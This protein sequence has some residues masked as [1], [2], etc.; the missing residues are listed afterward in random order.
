MSSIAILDLDGVIVDISL[1]A[2][3]ALELAET[4][5][6]SLYPDPDSETYK[7]ARRTFFY[8]ER[9]VFNVELIEL[10]RLILGCEKALEQLV[11]EYDKVVVLTSRQQSMRE[12]TLK[13]FSQSCPGFESI[14]FI[15]KDSDEQTIKTSTWKASV[16]ARF[17]ESYDTLL[18]I[19]DDERNRKAVEEAALGNVVIV[20]ERELVRNL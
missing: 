3:K 4:F 7:K 14:E 11:Q 20:I 9:G 16:I 1:H 15:F 5:A 12:A 10:D 19:D 17:A 6:I 18:F 13:W 8:S 2:Q